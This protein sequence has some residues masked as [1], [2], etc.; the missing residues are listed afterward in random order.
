MA[1][2]NFAISVFLVVSLVVVASAMPQNLI[3]MS[4]AALP[5][6]LA[7]TAYYDTGSTSYIDALESKITDQTNLQKR[8]SEGFLT[9]AEWRKLFDEEVRLIKNSTT[10]S[11]DKM[12]AL[13]REAAGDNPSAEA[14]NYAHG[15][16]QFFDFI[17]PDAAKYLNGKREGD[18][19]LWFMCGG[20]GIKETKRFNEAVKLGEETP[21]FSSS[22]SRI[23]RTSEDG[24][25][26]PLESYVWLRNLEI[27]HPPADLHVPEVAR[28]A[29]IVAVLHFKD[30]ST[31]DTINVFKHLYEKAHANR[32]TNVPDFLVL[33]EDIVELLN[34]SKRG[35]PLA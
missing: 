10:H 24:E 7:T 16:N 34:K 23:A 17:Y 14:E 15:F 33:D 13:A 26:M 8:D 18:K 6:P 1:K 2:I 35:E 28:L 3:E 11:D 31:N 30:A 5:T 21:G 22:L 9:S 27:L 25:Y 19:F 32:K 4:L 29:A 20:G 12:T